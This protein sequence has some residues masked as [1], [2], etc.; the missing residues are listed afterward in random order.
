MQAGDIIITADGTPVDRVSTLQR[1]VRN[2]APGEKVQLEV[3]RYGQKKSFS[4]TL[5]ELAEPARTAAANDPESSSR[6]P[7]S[8]PASIKSDA[9]GISLGAVPSEIASRANLAADRR[10]ALVTDVVPLGASYGK[11]FEQQDV[12]FEVLFPAP[13]RQIRTPAELQAVLS[14]LK[15]G[16]YISLNVHSLAPNGGGD[17]VVNIRLGE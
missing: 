4:V 5:T 15:S 1:I 14:Q 2:H 12:I 6:S 3:M 7:A 11:L 13:R 16:D 17:R 10:G 9:L 8:G